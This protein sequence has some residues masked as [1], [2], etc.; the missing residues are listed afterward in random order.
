MTMPEV[1]VRGAG[2][3]GLSVAWACA[4]RGA[5]VTVADPNGVG[6]GASGGL[7]GALAPHAPEQWS[8]AKAFQ[9][10]S[11]LMAGDWWAEV[12]ATGGVD[13]GYARAGRLQPVADEAALARARERIAGA[14]AHWQGVATWEVIRAD[15]AGPWAPVSPTGWLVRDTLSARLHPRRACASLAAALRARGA[16]IGADAQEAGLT[17]WATGAAGLAEADLG[18]GVKGQAALLHFEAHEHPQVYAGGVHIVPHMDGTVAVGST[19]ERDW[20][21]PDGTDAQL[22]DVLA[23]AVQ[24]M[25]VL[26]GAR[27]AERWAGLRPRARSRAPVLGRHPARPGAFIANGG[28][29]IGF[30]MAP[31]A[32]EVMADLLLEGRDR[33]PE[34]FRPERSL[35][36]ALR[37]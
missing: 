2:I 37:P 32:A 25:P 11:L 26:S 17:V 33:I 36:A 10:E 23:L 8:E 12:Q 27:V 9:L 31:L 1:T 7:V 22:E 28:F 4:R 15:A 18:R 21:D 5:R 13:P 20:N 29:K 30:G 19:T 6:A 16:C 24:A 3:F 34:S 35:T 14:E